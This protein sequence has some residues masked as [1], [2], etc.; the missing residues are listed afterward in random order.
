[1]KKLIIIILVV[2]LL[3]VSVTIGLVLKDNGTYKVSKTTSTVLGVVTIYE[4]KDYDT[5][6][7]IHKAIFDKQIV[8][9]R[10]Y[11]TLKVNKDD[12]ASSYKFKR[13][14]AKIVFKNGP[15]TLN[16]YTYS[17]GRV[18]ETFEFLGQ[19]YE[20]VYKR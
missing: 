17:R 6:D 12:N 19:T 18:Y 3:G 1:M 13:D 2:I 5:F 14:G 9:D 20:V 4:A 11:I 7:D 10:N 16:T 15:T 8:I